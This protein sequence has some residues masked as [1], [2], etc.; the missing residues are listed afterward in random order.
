M[1]QIVFFL[2]LSWKTHTDYLRVVTVRLWGDDKWSAG[3][4]FPTP[5]APY[6]GSRDDPDNP[7]PVYFG[8]G[9]NHSFRYQQERC[10]KVLEIYGIYYNRYL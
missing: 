6:E 7:L 2:N 9:H 8:E 3:N 5:T 4:P 1:I 10:V